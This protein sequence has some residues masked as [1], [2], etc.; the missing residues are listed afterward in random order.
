MVR[1]FQVAGLCF[2]LDLPDSHPV[3]DQLHNYDPFVLSRP[4][5]ELLND[6]NPVLRVVDGRA[7]TPGKGR[8]WRA[9]K[10]L[11]RY[12]LAACRRLCR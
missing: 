2:S 10:P 9:L 1:C 11:R 7:R 6:D 12:L 4:G 5:T 3:W 8:L